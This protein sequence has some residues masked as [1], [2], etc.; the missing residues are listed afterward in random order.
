MAT[1]PD[2]LGNYEL[3]EPVGRGGMGVIYRAVQ[4]SLGRTVALKRMHENLAADPEFSVRFEREARIAATLNHPNVVRVFDFGRDNDVCYLTMEWVDGPSLSMLLESQGRLPLA[5]AL[6]LAVDLSRALECA[7]RSGVIHRDVKPANVLLTRDGVA[8]LADFS[9]ARA[10]DLP[11]LTQ[12]GMTLGTPA[13]M[14]PEQFSGAF[15]TPATDVF[16]ACSLLYEAL[17]GR[18]AFP[19]DDR[20]QMLR[21]ILTEVPAPLDGDAPEAIAHVITRGLERDPSRRPA[22]GGELRRELEAAI[23]STGVVPSRDAVRDRIEAPPTLAPRE[24]RTRPIEASSIARPVPP[25]TPAPRRVRARA[26]AYAVLAVVAVAMAV[27][28][29]VSSTRPTSTEVRERALALRASE[30]PANALRWLDAE[31]ASHHELEASLREL[32]AVLETEALLHALSPEGK[33]TEKSPL[34]IAWRQTKTYAY[35]QV[36]LVAGAFLLERGRTG[37]PRHAAVKLFREAIDR[38]ARLANDPRVVEACLQTLVWDPPGVEA[39]EIADGILREFHP[40][41]RRRFADAHFD[42]RGAA[43]LRAAAI[44]EQVSDPRAATLWLRALRAYVREQ[45]MDANDAILRADSARHPQTLSAI[46]AA[47]D[48]D[49]I[50]YEDRE[51]A[52]K[53]AMWIEDRIAP[54][55]GPAGHVSVW[56][57]PSARVLM[58]GVEVSPSTPLVDWRVSAG[59]HQIRIVGDALDLACELTV[60]EGQKYHADATDGRTLR[61]SG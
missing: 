2:T 43:L 59:R 45:D 41:R 60:D 38:D 49:V 22:D 37:S 29:V 16:S 27:L 33:A 56:S 18:K 47:L 7:H 25:A 15:L 31:L 14:S 58:D 48:A 1:T 54:V 3:H 4:R 28:I 21:A 51:R 50:R 20:A 30:G 26:G 8:K 44:L 23:E 61:C 46:E 39:S 19:G 35:P 9:I 17:S 13:Y 10:V 40:E 36:P 5:A 53:L 12:S 42:G 52:E 55:S 6:S 32:R 57:W 11:G 34:E 24:G